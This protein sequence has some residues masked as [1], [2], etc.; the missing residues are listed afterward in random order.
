MQVGYLR[1]DIIHMSV[2]DYSANDTK[3]LT[4]FILT[5]KNH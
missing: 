4:S 1:A 3:S 5:K 2:I